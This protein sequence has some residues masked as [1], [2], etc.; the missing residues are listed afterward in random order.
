MHLQVKTFQVFAQ[1]VTFIWQALPPKLQPTLLELLFGA[2]IAR[3]GHITAAILAIRT[4]LSW[5]SYYKAIEQ[6]RFIWLLLAKRWLLLLIHVFN[7]NELVLTLDDFI[8]V[9]ASKKAPAVG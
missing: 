7:L 1:W 9:R 6:G 5:N 3:R 4:G 8:T 2:M